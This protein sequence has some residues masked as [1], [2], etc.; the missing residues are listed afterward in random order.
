LLAVDFL[1]ILA[2][3]VFGDDEAIWT[4]RPLLLWPL[5][6]LSGCVAAI[7]NAVV[8]LTKKGMQ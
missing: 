7:G 8:N 5:I 3:S 4:W 6:V 1:L 2:E